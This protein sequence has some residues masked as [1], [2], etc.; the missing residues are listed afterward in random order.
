MK[1]LKLFL[2]IVV[3]V[4]TLAS[5]SLNHTSHPSNP[6]D[7]QIAEGESSYTAI[8]SIIIQMKQ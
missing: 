4:L 5:C 8:I 7:D 1:K 3:L 2:T 6:G